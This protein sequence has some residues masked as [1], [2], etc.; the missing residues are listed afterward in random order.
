VRSTQRAF[1]SDDFIAFL[2]SI[3]LFLALIEYSIPKPFPFFRIGIANLP[4]LFAIRLLKIRHI[5]LLVAV[6]VFVLSLVQGTLVSYVF[7]FSS[8]GSI[9]SA[10]IMLILD[11]FLRDRISFI[12]IGVGGAL[13]SNVVQIVLA[14]FLIFGEAAWLIAPP[15]IAIGIASAVALG[16]FSNVFYSKSRWIKLIKSELAL[17]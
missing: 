14:R 10:G 7:L 4:I 8:A 9:T 16:L 2:A 1:N 6:K 15:L 12:G 3:S 17:V 13:T 5:A 11:R